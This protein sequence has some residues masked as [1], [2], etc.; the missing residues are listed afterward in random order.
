[1]F[2]EASVLLPFSSPPKRDSGEAPRQQGPTIVSL[3][4]IVILARKRAF[5]TAS[6]PLGEST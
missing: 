6:V 3:Q 5:R 1:M 4:S 2:E